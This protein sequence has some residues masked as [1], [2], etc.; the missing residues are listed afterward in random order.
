MSE[1]QDYFQLA[2]EAYEDL[3]GEIA[4]SRRV[5]PD[6]R[7]R[8]ADYTIAPGGICVG[9]RNQDNAPMGPTVSDPATGSWIATGEQAEIVALLQCAARSI[10]RFQ[11]P[12]HTQFAVITANPGDWRGFEGY[13]HNAGIFPVYNK[14]ADDFIFSLAAWAHNGYHPRQNIVL[15]VDDLAGVADMNA[16]T[17]DTFSWLAEHGPRLHVPVIAGDTRR[18]GRDLSHFGTQLKSIGAWQYVMP[19]NNVITVAR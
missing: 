1:R 4:A 19:D 2:Q 7:P 17:Q 3:Q 13:R 6:T 16:E 11:N 8:L 5:P 18:S 15:L 10:I 9:I 14:S 12:N